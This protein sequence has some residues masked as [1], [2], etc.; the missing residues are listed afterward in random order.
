MKQ[1]N[2]RQNKFS[3]TK[4]V[5]DHLKLDEPALISWMDENVPGFKGPLSL[6]EFKGGQSNPT[7]RIQTKNAFYVLRRKPPGELLPSAHAVDREFRVIDALHRQNF[8]VPKPYALCRDPDVLGTMFYVMEKVEGRIFWE[9]SLPELKPKERSEIYDSQLKTLTDLQAID[10]DRAGLRGFGKTDDYMARQIHRWTKIYNASETSKIDAMDK[11][12][13]WL[14]NNLP[15]SAGT[16]IIHGDYRLDNIIIDPK[17]SKV[18]AVL[19][20]ELSTLGDPL[21]DFVYHL[22]P[23]FLP[24]TKEVSS[25]KDLHLTDLGIP[26]E[27]DYINRYCELTGRERI[28]N[29]EFY[30][31]YTL[32][33]IAAIYQ[34]IIKRALDGTAASEDAI[35]DTD[36]VEIFA[37]RAWE[38][39]QA[40]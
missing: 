38:F 17:D 22:S 39:A 23:W 12:N 28:D 14:P 7:Y 20:W 4:E 15:S 5:Q 26:E 9:L 27:K 16:C 6:S 10:F 36:I 40:C 21:A 29:L 11:L 33:R 35:K 3:G 30:K 24:V 1:H 2:E 37:K 25:L 31:A 13:A 32:W 34:G 8:P 19:D 18:S